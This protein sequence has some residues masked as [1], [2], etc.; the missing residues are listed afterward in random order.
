M[1][2]GMALP[3]IRYRDG[4]IKIYT[5]ILIPGFW[6]NVYV[7]VFYLSSLVHVHVPSQV[8]KYM[9]HEKSYVNGVLFVCPVSY[10]YCHPYSLCP[11]L[12]TNS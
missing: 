8:V 12:C 3:K 4:S 10:L 2:I 5:S 7:R 11:F 1:N 6:H 9:C